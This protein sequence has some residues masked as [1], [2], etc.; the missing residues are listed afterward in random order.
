MLNLAG[1]FSKLTD[2]CNCSLKACAKAPLHRPRGWTW[3]SYQ[4]SSDHGTDRMCFLAFPWWTFSSDSY[5]LTNVI[6]TG[7]QSSNLSGIDNLSFLPLLARRMAGEPPSLWKSHGVSSDA[8]P[9]AGAILS[10]PI[11]IPFAF[12]PWGS[13]LRWHL[14]PLCSLFGKGEEK[15]EQLRWS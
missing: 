11:T 13:S 2:F 14:S 6:W 12:F 8:G 3:I 15:T 9:S 7:L 1:K 5:S 10:H 4:F